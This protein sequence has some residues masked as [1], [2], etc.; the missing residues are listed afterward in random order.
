MIGDRARR[1]AP[2]TTGDRLPKPISGRWATAPE[3]NVKR[4][5]GVPVDSQTGDLPAPESLCC[6]AAWL[7]VRRV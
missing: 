6:V 2:R 7:R 1:F 5:L 3:S 4:R